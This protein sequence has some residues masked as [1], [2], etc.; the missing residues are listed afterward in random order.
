MSSGAL[1]S[2]QAAKR[3]TL[4]GKNSLPNHIRA[5]ENGIEPSEPICKTYSAC[6]SK[7]T[8]DWKKSHLVRL[9]FFASILLI[10]SLILMNLFIAFERTHLQDQIDSLPEMKLEIQNEFNLTNLTSAQ[11]SK[12]EGKMR[13]YLAIPKENFWAQRPGGNVLRFVYSIHSTVGYGEVTPQT[14]TGK[15]LVII[16][17]ALGIAITMTIFV[18]L[19]K[20]ERNVCKTITRFLDANTPTYLYISNRW[21]RSAHFALITCYIILCAAIIDSF[22]SSSSGFDYSTTDYIYKYFCNFSTIGFGDDPIWVWPKSNRLIFYL[23]LLPFLSISIGLFPT[24]LISFWNLIDEILVNLLW[25]C[26]IKEHVV[27]WLC[28]KP[29]GLDLT[30]D[31]VYEDFHFFTRCERHH[32]ES[33]ELNTD[34][35]TFTRKDTLYSTQRQQSPSYNGMVCT[36]K[37]CYDPNADM[38]YFSHKGSCDST[39]RNRSS[40]QTDMVCT[41]KETLKTPLLNCP[42]YSEPLK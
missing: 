5:R 34:M 17:G 23:A 9:L 11:W 6:F 4:S 8:C 15:W 2:L 24:W 32:S 1:V 31:Q 41:M 27:R 18:E 10:W 22:D 37:E 20:M 38:V 19:F 7:E 25:H 13:T 16:G 21:F 42:T 40:S 26:G 14:V 30:R 3:R 28:F 35:V 29:E 39:H 36:M 33:Y 12:F